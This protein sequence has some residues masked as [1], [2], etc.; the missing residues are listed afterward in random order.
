MPPNFSSAKQVS[1]AALKSFTKHSES[2]GESFS[3]ES[4]YRLPT[5]PISAQMMEVSGGT[6][7]PAIFAIF[8]GDCPTHCGFTVQFG[9]ISSLP[10][11]SFWASPADGDLVFAGDLYALW[12][13]GG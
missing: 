7:K 5:P 2:T 9:M 12:C 8:V 6:S 3:A 13:H 10:N 11:A 1:R 4:G